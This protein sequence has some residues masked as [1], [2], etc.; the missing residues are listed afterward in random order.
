MN[1]LI[2][3]IYDEMYSEKLTLFNL[4]SNIKEENYISV[5]FSKEE[6]MI[7][8]E[9]S[10]ILKS[11]ELGTYRYYFLDDKLIRLV[12]TI[13]SNETELYNREKQLK[14]LIDEY[15]INLKRDGFGIA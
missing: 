6:S 11:E 7:V 1:S 4:V 12:E 3:K 9:T 2:E 15:K 10:C 5:N 13:N 14:E 8:C